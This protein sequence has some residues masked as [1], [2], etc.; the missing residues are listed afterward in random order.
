MAWYWWLVL[1]WIVGPM[2]I[3][4]AWYLLRRALPI[5]DA[6][7]AESD[8]GELRALRAWHLAGTPRRIVLRDPPEC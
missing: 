4:P 5:P 6:E 8:A 2:V 7:R 1:V 3:I